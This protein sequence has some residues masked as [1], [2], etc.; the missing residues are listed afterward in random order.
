MATKKKSFILD[1][2][3]E[4]EE[5]HDG[6]YGAPGIKREKKKK[7]TPEQVAKINQYNKE[8][9]A[10]RRL[11]QYFRENDWFVTLTYRK[12]AR[13]PDMKTVKKHFR[14]FITKVRKE[15]K[16]N[17][18]ELL[19][20]RNIENTKTNNW[21]IHLVINDI[22]DL[23]RLLNKL[24][25]HG[26]VH[27]SKQLYKRGGFRD[28]AAYITKDEKSTRKELGQIMDHV[29][30]E[31]SYSTSRNMP[32]KPLKERILKRWQEEPKPKQG[33]YIDKDS[34]FEGI[35]PVTGY[36]YRHYTMFRIETHRR[37]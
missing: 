2:V 15:Y 9:K 1:D 28:L 31:A 29:V 37:I 33:W 32:L 6:R 4:V 25:P 30:T 18:C 5:Y 12:D 23:I 13:P 8:K 17:D 24:W 36:K 35:N 16:K 3:I 21:H 14:T 10:R 19:W 26:T 22:P 20:I 27:D 7:A 34:Y 11:R